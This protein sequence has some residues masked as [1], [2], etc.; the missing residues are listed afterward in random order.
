M[1]ISKYIYI[2]IV[3]VHVAFFTT[4]AGIVAINATYLETFN[5]LVQIAIV[6]YLLYRFNP[7]TYRGFVPSY[8]DMIIIFNS[9]I[10][11]A[12][13]LGIKLL[14]SHYLHIVSSQIPTMF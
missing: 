13:N 1:Y 9:A 7:L 11:L 8:L 5:T 10:L 14:V 6:S 3:L 12:S 2:A 4:A